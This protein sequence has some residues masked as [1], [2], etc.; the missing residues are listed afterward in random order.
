MFAEVLPVFPS[1]GQSFHYTIPDELK[2][3]AGHLV[4]VSFGQQLIQGI[5]VALSDD[6]PQG[7]RDFKPV[8]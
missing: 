5:V 3:E 4:Q 2:V 7:V 6:P 8:Q 1:L